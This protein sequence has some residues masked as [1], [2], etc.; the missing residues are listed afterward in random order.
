MQSVIQR[1]QPSFRGLPTELILEILTYLAPDA[2]IS[3][4]FA[5]YHLLVRHSLASLLSP[6]TML[7]LFYQARICLRRDSSGPRSLPSEILRRL[8]PAD[9]LNYAMANYP[10]LA[11]QGIAPLLT[12]DT[13]HRLNRAV[14]RGR[15]SNSDT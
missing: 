3:F 14:R 4:G 15:G 9:A 11:S 13:L 5:N 7:R 6:L 8:E 2:L 1:P 12:Q 10:I